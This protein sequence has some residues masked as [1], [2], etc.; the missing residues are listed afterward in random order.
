VLWGNLA[1]PDVVVEARAPVTYT[2]YVDLEGRWIFDLEED[3]LTVT[4]PPIELGKPAIDP[5]AIRFE[6]LSSSIVRDEEAALEALRDSLSALAEH[7]GREHLPLVRELAETKIEQFVE[8]WVVGAF[9]DGAEYR[10][11]VVLSD[12]DRPSQ[13]GSALDSPTNGGGVVRRD[14]PPSASRR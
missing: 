9:G 4:A 10:I 5:S 3:R 6:T 1:L 7:R 8:T 14:H 12:E 13:D 2:Y 11:T